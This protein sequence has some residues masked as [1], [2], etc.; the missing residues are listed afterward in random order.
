M[1]IDLI[2]DL[3]PVNPEIELTFRQRRHE[4]TTQR[5]VEM[6]LGNQNQDQG[7][8]AD[9]VR[10]PI[11]IDDDRDQCIRQYVVPFFSELNP[12]I[13]R[14]DIGA[15]QFELKLVMFQ[16]LQTVGQF[17]GTPTE[18]PHLHLR[19]FMEVSDSFKIASVTKD[20]LRLKLFPYSLRDRTRLWLN[21]L[22][23]SSISTWQEL[24]ERFWLSTS[25]LAKMLS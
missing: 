8:E 4:R 9:H 16:M 22:P 3:L 5:Q 24:A 19:L 1:S 20:A 12:G 25:C 13:K 23:P 17:S 10:N 2:I 15:T 7:N 21:L 14:P 18:D 6:D 11:L